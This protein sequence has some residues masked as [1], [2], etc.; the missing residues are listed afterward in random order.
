MLEKDSH[1]SD[2]THLQTYK[3]ANLAKVAKYRR[4]PNKP[5]TATRTPTQNKPSPNLPDDFSQPKHSDS[6]SS[7]KS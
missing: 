7:L 3:V 4:W 6:L 2:K 5:S 1:L